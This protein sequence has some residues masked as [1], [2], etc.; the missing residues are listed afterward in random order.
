MVLV[1]TKTPTSV[2]RVLIRLFGLVTFKP[3]MTRVGIGVFTLVTV[4]NAMG[5]VG[6]IIVTQG[7]VINFGL[8]RGTVTPVVGTVRFAGQVLLCA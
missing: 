7:P 8:A 1:L 2:R 3:T 6:P 4:P 5:V